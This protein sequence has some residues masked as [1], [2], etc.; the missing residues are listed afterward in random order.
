MVEELRK[1]SIGFY[2]FPELSGERFHTKVDISEYDLVL[3]DINAIEKESDGYENNGMQR[4]VSNDDIS[5][6][7]ALG[8]QI[9]KL[10]SRRTTILIRTGRITHLHNQSRGAIP[11]LYGLIGESINLHVEKGDAKPS[12]QNTALGNLSSIKP[13][14]HYETYV[15]G[16]KGNNLLVSARNEKAIGLQLI[17]GE[18]Q[19]FVVPMNFNSKEAGQLYQHLLNSA[20]E[21]R[22]NVQDIQLPKI[23]QS[24]TWTREKAIRKQ[25]DK[26]TEEVEKL[27]A[28]LKEL[29]EQSI[30]VEK[31]KHLIFSDGIAFQNICVDAFKKLGFKIVDT[32]DQKADITMQNDT[33]KI[34]CEVKGKTKSAAEKDAAQLEKFILTEKIEN[35]TQNIKGI[36][37][38][39]AYRNENPKER[40]KAFPDQMIPYSKNAKHCLM[41]GLDLWSLV[42][43]AEEDPEK[44][45]EFQEKILNSIGVLRGSSWKKHLQEYAQSS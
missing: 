18:A 24:I 26:A 30:D 29:R 22:N 42:I 1:I 21:W 25:I 40:E 11:I 31:W 23:A 16:D 43:Q 45:T 37:V 9:E 27:S 5:K 13:K 3:I 41:T 32:S 38:I 17:L 19:I 35:D 4:S 20:E 36:L 34:I 14:W 33:Q 12:K 7:R 6:L 28:T 39:N 15:T 8:S 44:I 2:E 10:K